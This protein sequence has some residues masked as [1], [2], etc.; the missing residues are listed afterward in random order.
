MTRSTSGRNVSITRFT[1][2]GKTKSRGGADNA[3]I[4]FPTK[5]RA[6]KHSERKRGGE[7]VTVRGKPYVFSF[8]AFFVYRR[9]NALQ[10]LLQLR[11]V[12]C[13]TAGVGLLQMAQ[14]HPCE[15]GLDE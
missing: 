4:P 12:I 8:F 10:V 15:S 1:P 9:R 5:E 11:L 7:G 3:F 6:L 14:T 13:L 2:R